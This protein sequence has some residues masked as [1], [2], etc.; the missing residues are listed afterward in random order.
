MIPD[1]LKIS[2]SHIDP[3]YNEETKVMGLWGAMLIMA[4]KVV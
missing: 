1:R 2:L 4:L 3:A